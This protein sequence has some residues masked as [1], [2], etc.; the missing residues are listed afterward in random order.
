MGF[1]HVASSWLL[2]LAPMITAYSLDQASCSSIRSNPDLTVQDINNAVEE[3]LNIAQYAAFRMMPG[4]GIP[5]GNIVESLLGQN[6]RQT[7]IG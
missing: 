1:R 7:F 3:A 2:F 4:N 5:P 6:H